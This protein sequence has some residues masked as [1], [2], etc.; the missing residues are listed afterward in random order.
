MPEGITQ[1]EISEAEK[2]KIL[3]GMNNI[4]EE[5]NNKSLNSELDNAI[6]SPVDNVAPDT[7]DYAVV[8]QESVAKAPPS[9][10]DQ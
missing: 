6:I 9:I 8:N 2:A 3:A 1:T 7:D 5:L 4:I 10:K